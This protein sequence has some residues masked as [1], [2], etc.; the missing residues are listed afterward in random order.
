MVLLLLLALAGGVGSEPAAQ[1]GAVS[2][3][4]V[5]AVRQRVG[6]GAIVK[7]ESISATVGG[8]EARLAAVPDPGARLGGAVGFTILAGKKNERGVQTIRAGRATA[9]VRVWCAQIRL[10]RF[11]ARGVELTAADVEVV[12]EEL[13]GQPLRR[14]LSIEEVVGGRTVRDLAEGASVTVS[15]V[16]AQPM[17]RTGDEVQAIAHDAEFEVTAT[18]V[19]RES[20]SAGAIVRVRNPESR[21]I[22]RA[23][24]LSKGVVEILP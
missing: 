10:T 18:M 24:V 23:R 21:R 8:Q 17:V 5:E 14:P 12:H 20:G 22:V 6:A 3:A 9:T 19:A 11:V 4:L 13:I 16:V 1:A 2:R 7:V 15:A